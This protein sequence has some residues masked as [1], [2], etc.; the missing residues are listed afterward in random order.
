MQLK[1]GPAQLRRRLIAASCAL[2]SAPAARSQ[3]NPAPGFVGRLLK[4]WQFESALAYYHEDGRIQ[5]VEPVVN[6]SHDYGEGGNVS[7]NFTFDALTGSSPNGAL[8]SHAPQTFTS[9]SAKS[10]AAARRVYTTAPGRL[11]VDPNFSDAR[12]A[13]GADWTLPLTR[14]S[15]LTLAGKASIEDDFYSGT[16]NVALAHDFNDK[17]TTVSLGATVEGDIVQP[18]GN[19]PVPLSN[20]VAWERE[21]NKSKTGVGALFGV[22]QV[23]TRNWLTQLNVSVDRF[24]GYLND[25]YKI[26]SVLDAGGD[27]TGYVY[28]NR[29][30]SRTRKS[31]YLENRVGGAHASAGLSLRYMTDSWGIRSETAQVRLRLWNPSRQQYIEPTT[32]WYHQ[33][34]AEFFNPWLA[35]ADAGSTRYVSSDPRVATFHALTYGLKYGYDL[36]ERLHRSNSEFT[37]RVEYYRQTL[38]VNKPVPVA[39]Q[40]LELY[41][42]LRVVF[43]QFGFSY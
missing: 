5:A 41:P 1:S 43:V 23:M 35:A 39:L 18:V 32:R 22:T 8:P 42:G 30:D 27:T 17:N 15:R 3:E 7:L 26:V 24:T 34:A 36:G 13:F 14:L 20:Y 28:E 19:T 11:P 25:P 21:G 12:A 4:E 37:V 9:S 38:E 10:F 40:G 16:L 6:A 2:L 33:S 29:P 31:A